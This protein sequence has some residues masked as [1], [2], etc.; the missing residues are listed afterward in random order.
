MLARTTTHEAT[1]KY[2]DVLRASTGI[3]SKQ[4]KCLSHPESMTSSG[5]SKPAKLFKKMY[6]ICRSVVDS[7]FVFGN[8]WHSIA[9]SNLIKVTSQHLDIFLGFSKA[10]V[11]VGDFLQIQ[12]GS[13]LSSD[14]D[15]VG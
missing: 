13:K 15:V 4:P 14:P 6:D 5:D 11:Q 10:T 2:V 7:L 9:I 12:N 1:C 8:Q 3:R